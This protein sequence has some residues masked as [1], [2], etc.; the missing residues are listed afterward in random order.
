MHSGRS[1]VVRTLTD[2]AHQTNNPAVL[3]HD[4]FKSYLESTALVASQNHRAAVSLKG[5]C[6]NINFNNYRN[7]KYKPD[8]H[9]Y[10]RS[11]FHGQFGPFT[12]DR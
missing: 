5:Y 4:G 12:A 8:G 2:I 1:I 6:V 10:Y 11:Q 3:T 7:F 9:T